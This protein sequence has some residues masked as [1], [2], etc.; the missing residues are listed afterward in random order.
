[1]AADGGDDGRTAVVM[2]PQPLWVAAITPILL[3][4]DI[5]VV[6]TATTARDALDELE[7]HRPDLFV[8]E[9]AVGGPAL[10][11]EARSLL[12]DLRI[13]AIAASA[14]PDQVD[15][16]LTAG[17]VAYVIKTAQPADI[18]AGIRQAFHSSIFLP[19]PRR[20]LAQPA[21]AAAPETGTLTPRE[22]EILKLA[23]AGRPN[24]ELARMLWVTEQTVKFHLSNI[25]RKLGVANRTEASRWAQ[26]NGLLD[27]DAGAQHEPA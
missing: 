18:R 15:Q 2:D 1:V 20:P 3:E 13:V 24:A 16:A 14:D 4:T 27:E 26:L 7:R 10:L 23:A 9:P 19:S 8:V 21:A 25:Y 6:A 22:V 17:A 5:A 12:P 11:A